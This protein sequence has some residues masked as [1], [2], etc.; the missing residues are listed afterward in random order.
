MPIREYFN[1]IL[2]TLCLTTVLVTL[3]TYLIFRIRYS[4]TYDKN[5]EVYKIEGQ[6]FR[7]YAPNLHQVNQ[8]QLAKKKRKAEHPGFTRLKVGLVFLAA[9]C[10]VAVLLLSENYLL[11]RS[12]LKSRAQT[13]EDY[14]K[15]IEAGLMKKHDYRPGLQISLDEYTT[16]RFYERR[17]QLVHQFSN[18]TV[19]LFSNDANVEYKE[20]VHPYALEKWK[21]FLKRYKISYQISSK[22]SVFKTHTGLLVLPQVELFSQEKWN[23]LSERMKRGLP[24]YITGILGRPSEFNRI[25]N[26]KTIENP[27]PE[28]EPTLFAADQAPWWDLSPGTLIPWYP[29]SHKRRML[30]MNGDPAV[31]V[32][33]GLQVKKAVGKSISRFSPIEKDGRRIL[34]SALDP[35][36]PKLNPKEAEYVPL[37]DA[38]VLSAMAWANYFKQARVSSWKDGNRTALVFSI[39]AEFQFKDTEKIIEKLKEHKLP[40]TTFVVSDLYKEHPK[41]FRNLEDT[42]EIASHTDDHEVMTN[43][44]AAQNFVRL[45]KSRFDI[46]EIRKQEVVGFRP[47]EEKFNSDSVNAI[48]QNGFRYMF[49]DRSVVRLAPYWISKGRLLMMPRVVEDDFNLKKNKLLATPEDVAIQMQNEVERSERFG[50]G[51]FLSIHSQVSGDPFYLESLDLFLQKV[52]SKPGRWFTTFRDIESW[53]RKRENIIV[54]PGSGRNFIVTNKGKTTFDGGILFIQD[55]RNLGGRTVASGSNTLRVKIPKLIPRQVKS[56]S[57]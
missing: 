39:D 50:G 18:Q 29:T 26:V 34:W 6:F 41:L 17:T 1:L 36:D 44:D 31:E 43:L 25:L 47:P 8:D 57:Y 13:A 40:L 38:A 19:V 20:S 10:V 2:L 11:F 51:Y 46:E 28:Y 27:K 21:N 48:Q 3:V 56:V 4:L 45:E 55:P 52:T 35:L 14:R 49:G 32:T 33:F 16:P 53:W 24:I 12:D 5:H 15:L 23:A 37:A 30:D 22:V 9:P 42:D 54:S 7:R